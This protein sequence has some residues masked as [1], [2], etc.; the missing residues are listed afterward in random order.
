MRK[1]RHERIISL[2]S[3]QKNQKIL[4]K[5]NSAFIRQD[6]R[7]DFLLRGLV[8]CSHCGTKLTGANS[9]SKT[10]WL[11]PYYKCPNKDCDAYGKSI[12]A[13][14]IHNGFISIIKSISA[15]EELQTLAIAIFDDVWKEEIHK[16]EKERESARIT[17]QEVG[18]KIT[19]LTLLAT[20]TQL[21]LNS[22]R[23]K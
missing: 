7:E 8:N 18:N 21:S 19:Q 9:R 22:M 2:N 23:T 16:E 20:K 5:K 15:S 6:I 10:G 17:K 1:G 12:R 11:Y 13:E 4:N 3:F 14:D